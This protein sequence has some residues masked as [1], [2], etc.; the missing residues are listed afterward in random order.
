MSVQQVT[1]D[2]S[3]TSWVDSVPGVE[4]STSYQ[5]QNTSSEAS[6]N[7][8]DSV[9]FEVSGSTVIAKVSGPIDENGLLF[10]ITSEEV[11]STFSA[12]KNY[13]YLDTGATI[14][15]RT[16]S[17][18]QDVPTFDP[19][20]NGWYTAGNQRVFN[21]GVEQIDSN[22]G[23][24]IGTF[25]LVKYNETNGTP[26]YFRFAYLDGSTPVP[27]GG[28]FFQATVLKVTDVEWKVSLPTF[29]VP[30]GDVSSAGEYVFAFLTDSS[31]NFSIHSSDED[32]IFYGKEP[33]FYTNGN[34]RFSFFLEFGG[35]DSGSGD[36][37]SCIKVYGK[38]LASLGRWDLK[39]LEYIDSVSLGEAQPTTFIF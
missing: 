15:D 38:E 9:V 37:F 5:S 14:N 6:R 7:G 17:V 26:F 30:P 16:I 33:R 31:G 34:D 12:G 3:G 18:T 35:C 28:E 19:E 10:N 29:V 1:V 11:L 39:E 22:L 36:F 8:I 21:T 4:V 27:V 23:K 32:R 20:K 25:D 2:E 24:S 13:L